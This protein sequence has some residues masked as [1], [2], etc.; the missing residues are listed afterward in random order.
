MRQEKRLVIQCMNVEKGKMKLRKNFD[1]QLIQNAATECCAHV[2]DVIEFLGL[3]YSPQLAMN[4][5][6]VL[7]GSLS[8]QPEDW[9][10]YMKNGAPYN[11]EEF[12]KKIE[13]GAA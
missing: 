7:V 9:E 11:N 1:H 2:C 3:E 4:I 8:K 5:A 6:R 13:K 12:L 10:D